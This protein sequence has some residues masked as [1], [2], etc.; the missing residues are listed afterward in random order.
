VSRCPFAI[1]TPSPNYT[2]GRPRGVIGAMEHSTAST[3]NAAVTYL[4][5]PRGTSSTSAHFVIRNSDGLIKQLVDTSD[6]A[7]HARDCNEQWVGIEHDDNGDPYNL[8][9]SDALYAAS[10]DLNRWLAE[11]H[12]Y[13]PDYETMQPHRNC[14]NTA[15]PAGLDYERLVAETMGVNMLS[16]E[17][18]ERWLADFKGT[19]IAYIADRLAK[20]AHHGH[21]E[22]LEPKGLR[23][24]QVEAR[25]ITADLMKKVPTLALARKMKGTVSHAK[26]G[27]GATAAE[28]A[29]RR[30]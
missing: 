24:R 8:V 18:F 15:C 12:G 20:D 5:T 29:A 11:E 13:D 2:P 14:V 17:D 16:R 23:A 7:W 26:R 27:H 19:T 25:R 1:W 28:Y 3:F 22:P 6:R 30:R 10:A 21:G 9:R 4:C